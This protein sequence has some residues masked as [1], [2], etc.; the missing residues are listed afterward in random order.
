M[1]GKGW[2]LSLLFAASITIGTESEAQ[3]PT[4]YQMAEPHLREKLRKS[5]PPTSPPGYE[6]RSPQ[7]AVAEVELGY[8]GALIAVEVVEAPSLEVMRR[9]ESALRTWTFGS[10]GGDPGARFFS[11]LTF[12]FVVVDGVTRVL[13]PDEMAKHR[14][15]LMSIDA[16]KSGLRLTTGG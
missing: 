14:K 13:S 15:Q 3:T 4:R 16:K 6:P 12:Y 5:V 1:H 11:K 2:L 8:D 10:L 7:V 9:I